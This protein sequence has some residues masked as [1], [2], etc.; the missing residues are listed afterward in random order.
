MQ[1]YTEE[2]SPAGSALIAVIVY[3][4][5]ASWKYDFE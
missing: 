1:L 4:Q 5:A 3:S 2:A